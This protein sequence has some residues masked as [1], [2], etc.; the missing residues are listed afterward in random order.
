MSQQDYQQDY[1][2][3]VWKKDVGKSVKGPAQPKVQYDGSVRKIE[4]ESIKIPTVTREMGQKIAQAR[5]EKGWTQVQLAQQCNL[6]P[7]IVAEYEK[8]QGKYERK[9]LDPICKKLGLVLHKPPVKKL[10]FD[11]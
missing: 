4:Q 3:L 8:G 9:H 6:K 7:S 2:P 11:T 5:R 1:K 10:E